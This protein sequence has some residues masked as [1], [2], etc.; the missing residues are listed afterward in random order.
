[1]DSF[2]IGLGNFIFNVLL[3]F[4]DFLSLSNQKFRMIFDKDNSVGDDLEKNT[5]KSFLNKIKTDLGVLTKRSF[6]NLFY[7]DEDYPSLENAK[8]TDLNDNVFLSIANKKNE[9]VALTNEKKDLKSQNDIFK[10]FL[11]NRQKLNFDSFVK[12]SLMIVLILIIAVLFISYFISFEVGLIILLSFVLLTLF[13]VSF[14]KIKKENDYSRF[15]REL[16]YALRQLATELR[17][18]KSLFDSLNSIVE[19]DYD[20]LSHEFSRVLQELKYGESTETAFI[21]LN[22]RVQSPALSRANQEILA[23]LRVGGNL[24]KS[25]SIIAED[26]NFDMRMKLKE[27][28]QKLNAFIMIYTF[29]AILAPVIVLTMLLAASVVIGDIVPANLVLILYALF[30]PMIILFLAFAIKKLEP[31]V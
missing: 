31:K 2:F 19:A 15:S 9:N 16:P 27:Y 12:L 5:N 14:P 26:V 6:N 3:V 28:A 13:F 21:H 7:G 30:F 11:K 18:G 17:S 25:L 24:S 4:L 29:L 1:M 20:V 8:M 23:T 10:Q 22:K